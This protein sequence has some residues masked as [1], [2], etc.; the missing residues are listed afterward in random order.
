MRSIDSLPIDNWERDRASALVKDEA[1]LRR[2]TGTQ[3][4]A[5]PVVD[6]GQ[7]LEELVEEPVEE[8]PS[9]KR[10]LIPNDAARE[11]FQ[12]RAKVR[13][14]KVEMDG[15]KEDAKEAKQAYDAATGRL[16]DLVDELKADSNSLFA[17]VGPL[18][19][20]EVD[21]SGPIEDAEFDPD[22]EVEDDPGDDDGDDDGDGEL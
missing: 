2:W 9:S 7:A 6:D 21:E 16:L 10:P 18:D 8:P 22:F 11:L 14:R 13:L 12:L 19:E 20:A 5:E 4:M 3:T 15:A 17:G 1:H